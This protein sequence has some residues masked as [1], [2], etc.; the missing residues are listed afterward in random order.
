MK[1]ILYF[2]PSCIQISMNFGTLPELFEH[3][4]SNSKRKEKPGHWTVFGPGLVRKWAA[5]AHQT[6]S[7][8]W[9]HGRPWPNR[10]PRRRPNFPA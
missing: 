5:K 7:L 10:V 3:Y 8:A 4:K 6:H 2:F 1:F 9:L